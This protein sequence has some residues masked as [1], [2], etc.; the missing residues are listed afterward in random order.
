M[1]G[2][3]VTSYTTWG[4]PMHSLL[5]VVFSLSEPIILSLSDS[6]VPALSLPGPP[7]GH[8]LHTS[9]PSSLLSLTF[10]LEFLQ[11]NS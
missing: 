4:L 9:G 6:S 2:I 11:L 5:R 10:D 8:D 7:G 3:D 1:N